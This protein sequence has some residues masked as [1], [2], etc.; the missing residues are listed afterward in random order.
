MS[1]TSERLRSLLMGQ[2]LHRAQ[3]TP[4]RVF[5]TSTRVHLRFRLSTQ[6]TWELAMF[7]VTNV[8]SSFTQ[9]FLRDLPALAL[10]LT[11]KWRFSVLL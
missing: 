4:Q 9:P 5:G 11:L 2:S 10:N 6:D 3:T 7:T 1:A 8:P